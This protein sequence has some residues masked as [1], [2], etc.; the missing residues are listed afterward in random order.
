MKL[1]SKPAALELLGADD[2][3]EGIPGDPLREV[4]RYCGAARKRLGEPEVLVIESPVRNAELVERDEH[5]DRS[6]SREQGNPE[7]GASGEVAHHDRVDLRIVEQ[8]VDPF[9]P[10]LGQDPAALRFVPA[11]SL[12]EQAFASL[13]RSRGETQLVGAVR[14][15]HR[16]QPGLEQLA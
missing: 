3:P 2:S 8:G 10:S 1:S 12:A 6:A 7:A 13:P 16:D 11:Q 15:E 14:E 4:D 5:A 9:A